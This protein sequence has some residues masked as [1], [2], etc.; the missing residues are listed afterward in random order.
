MSFKI[1][2]F[3]FFKTAV[4]RW[5]CS[6]FQSGELI[7]PKSKGHGIEASLHFTEEDAGGF[8]LQAV[9]FTGVPLVNG[10]PQASVFGLVGKKMQG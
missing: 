9:L 8:H 7:T 1:Y 10:G 4:N 2:S 5:T 6:N 3:F